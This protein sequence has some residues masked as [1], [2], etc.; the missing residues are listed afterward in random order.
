MVVSCSREFKMSPISI[1]D[2]NLFSKATSRLLKIDCAIVVS[3]QSLL[4]YATFLG[5]AYLITK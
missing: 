1:A 3:F 4:T 2:Q 5:G